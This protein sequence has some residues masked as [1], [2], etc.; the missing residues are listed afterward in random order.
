M[1]KTNIDWPSLGYSWNPIVGCANGCSYCYAKK[2]SDRF[3]MVTDFT[4]PTFFPQR[5]D[6]PTKIKKP[7]T[8]FVGSMCDIF[9]DGVN[10]NWIDR[11]IITAKECPQHT[12]MF[13]TKNPEMYEVWNWPDNCQLGTTIERY[14]NIYRQYQFPANGNF[15]FLSIEPILSS[16]TGIEFNAIDLIIVGADSTKGAKL[17]PFEWVLS[18]KH[19]NIYYKKNLRKYYPE[20][21]NK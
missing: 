19:P 3:K 2:I 7:A 10:T 11:I 8:I 20:L 6:E 15:R 18:I 13:L 17:P 1:N 12:F 21:I 9:S 14:E 5:I 4:E 16:F